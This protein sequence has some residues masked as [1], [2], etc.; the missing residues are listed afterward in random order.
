MPAWRERA[1]SSSSGNKPSAPREANGSDGIVLEDAEGRPGPDSIGFDL[2][3]FRFVAANSSR[4]SSRS[5]RSSSSGSGASST[6]DGAG[7]GCIG[8]SNGLTVEVSKEDSGDLH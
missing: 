8:A 7:V 5:S 4:T 1:N 2:E 6:A 3:E